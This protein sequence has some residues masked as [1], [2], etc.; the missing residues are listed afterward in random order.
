MRSPLD[1]TRPLWAVTSYFNPAGYRRRLANYR[2]FRA[3]LGVP[4]VC[5]EQS[6]TG[7]FEL[8]AADADLLLQLTG[9][10]MW[11]KERLLNV[12]ISH[13]PAACRAV[14]WID[15]DVLFERAEWPALTLAALE[16]YPL[17]HL[18]EERVDLD[19]AAGGESPAAAPVL[20]TS[21]SL[22]ARRLAGQARAA[23][24]WDS[25]APNQLGTSMGLAWAARRELLDE[26]GLYDACI[27]GSG[28]RVNLC[29][30]CGRY[31]DGARA[32]GMNERQ[33]AHYLR[34]AEP[35]HRDVAGQVGH[36]PGRAY[37][38][39]HG[40]F[41]HR[42]YAARHE[43]LATFDFDPTT[44]LALSETGAWRWNSDKPAM[45]TY[46]R[47]YFDSRREDG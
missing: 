37:H 1:D 7:Q 17:V 39:W 25:N 38:L 18:Y 20:R 35:F 23:D 26:H 45:H 4:L 41:E 12:A 13:L 8:N 43:G 27:L 40:E 22:I 10:C 28:D 34:W 5:V 14:A 6:C 11:Q 2:T 16:R 33:R 42:A 19:R 47:Q 32:T 21:H 29:G 24:Y 36:L 30:S 44:D 46:V 9:D 31:D 3:Q 15:A